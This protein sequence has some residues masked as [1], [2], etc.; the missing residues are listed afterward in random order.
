[1][2]VGMSLSSE[3]RTVV[4]DALKLYGAGLDGDF[5]VSP[6]GKKLAV[7]VESTQ[8]RLRFESVTATLATAPISSQGV[9]DFVEKF[10]LWKKQ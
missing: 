3:A 2:V 7:W 6:A 4:V 1:M 9:S 5:I 8:Q 10:W